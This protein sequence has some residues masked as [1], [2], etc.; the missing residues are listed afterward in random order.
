MIFEENPNPQRSACP[1]GHNWIRLTRVDPK[2]TPRCP[3]HNPNPHRPHN[4]HPPNVPGGAGL[5]PARRT[6]PQNTTPDT[7][8]PNQPTGLNPTPNRIVGWA[9]GKNRRRR[10][11]VS[12][13]MAHSGRRDIDDGMR[14]TTYG[15]WDVTDATRITPTGRWYADGGRC[16]GPRKVAWVIRARRIENGDSRRRAGT[17][18]GPRGYMGRVLWRLVGPAYVSGR[19]IESLCYTQEERPP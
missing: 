9:G 3:R 11:A 15:R 12:G 14:M 5:V 10:I 16:G 19:S 13:T 2:Y 1:N 18:R 6:H 4:P 7:T 8:D 17:R